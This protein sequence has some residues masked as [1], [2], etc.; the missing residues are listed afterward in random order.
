MAYKNRLDRLAASKRNYAANRR[1][2]I[3]KAKK[4]KAELYARVIIPAK[5]KPCADCKKWFPVICMDFDHVFGEKKFDIAHG[6]NQVS[7]KVLLEEISKCEVVCSNCHRIRTNLRAVG[8]T[9]T[10][11][12]Y[13]PTNQS[14]TL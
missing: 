2:Y 8:P 14:G 13:E 7:M 9:H 10:T 4:R 12:G 1:T 3:E 5:S 11:V 6:Y